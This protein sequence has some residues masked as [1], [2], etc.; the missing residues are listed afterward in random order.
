MVARV[1]DAVRLADQ[2]LTRVTRDGAE[3]VVH[4]RDHACPVGDGDD[5]VRVQG[6]PQF[7]AFLQRRL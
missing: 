7:P 4:L 3:L 5:G 6:L 1:D 2:L